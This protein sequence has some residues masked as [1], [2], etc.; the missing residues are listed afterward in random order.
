[1]TMSAPPTAAAGE[2]AT[3]PI[4][5]ASARDRVR[6]QSVGSKPAPAIRLAIAAPILPVPSTAIRGGS[7]DW[8][9]RAAAFSRSKW[10]CGRPE[11]G[12]R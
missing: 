4:S 8:P 3:V 12:P 5:S 1:M 11:T 6:F 9:V 10:T 7:L 2:S